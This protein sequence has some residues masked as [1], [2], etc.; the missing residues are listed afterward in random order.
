MK[1]VQCPHTIGNE[2]S[3]FL[4]KYQRFAED[5]KRMH[6]KIIEISSQV[7]PKT[8]NRIIKIFWLYEHQV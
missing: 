8:I 4:I 2:Q 1:Y 3:D 6:N 5:M 7:T